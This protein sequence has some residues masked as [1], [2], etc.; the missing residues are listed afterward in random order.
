[1]ENKVHV[2][3][4]TNFSSE[5]E[6][7]EYFELDYSVEGD[8]N[9]PNY[10]QCAF[11]KDIGIQWYDDDFIGMIPRH[12]QEVSLDEILLDA[13]VDQD[14]L[15]LVKSECDNLGIKKANAIFWYQDPNLV[16]KRPIKDQYN[17]LK[18]IGL[19]N[20]D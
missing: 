5:E 7:M 16:I 19:F 18:Y 6:Y 4:G 15:S 12:K 14:E 10:R 20:G 17:W 3:I 11:C 13:A 1:M 9:N 8:F 2:W